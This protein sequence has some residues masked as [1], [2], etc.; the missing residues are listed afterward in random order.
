M[1]YNASDKDAAIKKGERIGQMIIL[2]YPEVTFEEVDELD[3][4]NRGEGGFGSTGK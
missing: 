1:V 3:E 4:S 2:P